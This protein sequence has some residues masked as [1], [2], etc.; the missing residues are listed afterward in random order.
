MT[1]TSAA[2]SAV[3]ELKWWGV[4]SRRCACLSLW[5][6]E[7]LAGFGGKTGAA[8]RTKR[9]E[10][11]EAL[12]SALTASRGAPHQQLACSALPATAG[13]RQTIF[14]L[15]VLLCFGEEEQSKSEPD[16]RP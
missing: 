12:A 6:A 15:F 4:V 9:P 1:E 7:S 13:L 8:G 3:E 2:F 10:C 11:K 5:L 14:S 16:S